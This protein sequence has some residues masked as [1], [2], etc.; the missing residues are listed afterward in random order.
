MDLP[1][2]QKVAGSGKDEVVMLVLVAMGGVG[3]SE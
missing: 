1:G 3:E 2:S